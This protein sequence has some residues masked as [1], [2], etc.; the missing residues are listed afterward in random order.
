M[1]EQ[2]WLISDIRPQVMLRVQ[3]TLEAMGLSADSITLGVPPDPA[4][5]DIGF[6]C[7]PFAKTARKAPPLIA[8]E[9]AARIPADELVSKVTSDG[10]Y[11]NIHIHVAVRV[12]VAVGQALRQSNRFG[13]GSVALRDR[14]TWMVEYSAPNT[15]KPQHL[16]HIRNNLLGSSFTRLLD[17]VGHKVIPVNLINDRG[18][19]ICKSMLAYQ[20]F[21][22]GITPQSSG[23][24]G[25]HLVGEFYVL[26][27][28]K[29]SEEY[30]EWLKTPAATAEFDRWLTT[31]AG[32]AAA[33]SHAANPA[34]PTAEQVFSKEYKQDYFNDYSELGMAAR[35]MLRAWEAGDAEVVA[36]WRMMNQWVFAGFD[37]TYARLG[38]RFDRVY[39]ESDTW[40]LGKKVVEDALKEGVF[41]RLDDGAVVFDLQRIGKTGKKVLLRRDGTTVYMTQDLGTFMARLD[42]YGLERM[43]YVVADEQ[44]YHFEVLFGILGELRPE[45]K[46][47]CHHLSYGMVHLPEGKMK[48]REGTVVDADDLMDTMAELAREEIVRREDESRQRA[49]AHGDLF[50]PLSQ[51]EI[52][53]RAEIIGLAAIK[54]YVLNFTPQTTVTF[55]PKRS[56]DFLGQTG[57]YCLYSYARVQSLFRKAGRTVDVN[58][59]DETT[60]ALLSSPLE[61]AVVR[62]L[63]AFLDAVNYAGATADTSK[64]T[65]QV[66]RIAKTFS[67]L[68]N[69]KEHQIVGN[70]DRH[71][72]TARLLLAKA[73]ANAVKTGLSL[74]GIETLEQM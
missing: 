30:A 32:I 36:L 54:Y 35:D 56:I 57:P 28:K 66:Y 25:D 60:A 1:A 14:K 41:E 61:L 27:E 47:A 15:N 29:F 13:A 67:T 52:A 68:Y 49:E 48:S 21:G 24:K 74:L 43:T 10:P 65:E 16:G 40:V 51:A 34:E 44:A 2:L 50:E 58:D 70:A 6:P 19:H 31:R 53:R 71:V 17:F 73:V 23:I 8:Q 37:A 45:M 7:F 42:E 4:M 26:F 20:R 62:E 9:V 3:R 33:K 11:V 63:E 12:R 69:D 5:G 22:N 55:D 59:L 46:G 18:I 39:Y 38:V 64:V 72:E